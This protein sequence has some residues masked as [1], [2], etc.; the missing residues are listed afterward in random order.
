M[1][2]A[3]TPE[4]GH[5]RNSLERQDVNGAPFLR[6]AMRLSLRFAAAALLLAASA[7]AQTSTNQ[8]AGSTW[9]QD[10]RSSVRQ[11]YSFGSDGSYA[12]NS[13][14]NTGYIS[15]SGGWVLI[16]RGRRIRLRAD[17]RVEVRNGRERYLNAQRTFVL[18]IADRGYST[19]IVDGVRF[20]RQ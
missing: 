9:V 4:P 16:D 3:R 13:G 6:F 8:I 17:Q 1:R 14:R 10:T 5:G 20:R 2:S 15:H 11:S 19:I 12:F 18:P 7:S